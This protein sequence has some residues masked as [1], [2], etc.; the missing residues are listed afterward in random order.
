MPGLNVPTATKLPL[1]P[2]VASADGPRD[3]ASASGNA[4]SAMS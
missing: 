1:G 4:G 3:H 2:S